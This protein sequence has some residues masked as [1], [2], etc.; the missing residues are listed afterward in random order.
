MRSES[1]KSENSQS[2]IN[3]VGGHVGDNII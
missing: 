2:G 3:Q 1:A